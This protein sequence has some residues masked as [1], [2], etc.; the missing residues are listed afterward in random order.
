MAEHRTLFPR[1]LH[2][3]HD[4]T[5][6]PSGGGGGE[7]LPKVFGGD[8]RSKTLMHAYNFIGRYMIFH[9]LIIKQLLPI[10]KL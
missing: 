2:E 3:N 9:T 1:T 8:V 7:I 4:G 5:Q 6:S 10:S